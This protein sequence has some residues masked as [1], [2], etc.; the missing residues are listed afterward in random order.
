[1]QPILNCHG[2]PTRETA[3]RRRQEPHFSPKELHIPLNQMQCAIWRYTIGLCSQQWNYADSS[4]ACTVFV[5][6]TQKGQVKPLPPAPT[7]RSDA[8][9]R[10]SPKRHHPLNVVENPCTHKL[11]RSVF[12]THPM[13]TVTM[14]ALLPQSL[15]GIPARRHEAAFGYPNRGCQFK[16]TSKGERLS[17]R[18]ASS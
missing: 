17:R 1:M 9:E 3:H 6:S 8:N 10:S 2:N 16:L 7:A 13:C 15:R 11:I 18:A 12:G 14:T 4:A 5:T